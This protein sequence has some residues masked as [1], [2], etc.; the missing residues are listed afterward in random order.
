M[1]QDV[2]LIDVAGVNAF[3]AH[4]FES[5][6]EVAVPA[7]A[8]HF[9]VGHNLESGFDLAVDQAVDYAVFNGMIVSIAEIAADFFVQSIFKFFGREEAAHYFNAG[10]VDRLS[11]DKSVVFDTVSLDWLSEKR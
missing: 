1:A 4:T 6:P 8:A 7:F 9:A 5:F 10:H 2:V 11:H 3:A